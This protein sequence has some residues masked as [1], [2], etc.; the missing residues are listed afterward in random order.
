MTST[1]W[2]VLTAGLAAAVWV[3]WYFFLAERRG[4]TAALATAAGDVQQVEIV[5]RGAYSPATV[6]VAAGRPVRLLFDRQ[7][8]SSC[9]EEVVFP[10]FGVRRF[11][12]AHEK[13]ALEITPP[14]PGTY[15]FTCGMG[16]L[17]GRLIAE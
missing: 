10:A 6:R 16:M 8:T 13:T 17:H 14:V 4:A 3:N 7:E 2:L 9:S 11:L 1:D 5:V 15:D 12:P